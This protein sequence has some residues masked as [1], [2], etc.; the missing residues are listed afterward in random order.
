MVRLVRRL[1]LHQLSLSS[2]S[3][4]GQQH[5]S[6]PYPQAAFMYPRASALFCVNWLNLPGYAADQYTL[7]NSLSAS[8][9]YNLWGVDFGTKSGFLQRQLC[10]DLR[11]SFAGAVLAR[12]RNLGLSYSA[13]GYAWDLCLLRPQFSRPGQHQHLL[14][15][16]IGPGRSHGHCHAF[17]KAGSRG[18]ITTLSVPNRGQLIGA[19]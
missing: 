12:Y 2:R 10:A 8:W 4:R 6:Q 3:A 18:L 13:V 16:R 9:V 17:R 11:V 19:L 14:A 5:G 15:N 7:G 1:G